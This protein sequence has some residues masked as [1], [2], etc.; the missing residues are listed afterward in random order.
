M[1]QG[2]RRIVGIRRDKV[3]E[4]RRRVEAGCKFQ[5]VAREVL[6]ANAQLLVLTN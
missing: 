3:A 6:A 5:E 4:A 1:A 2:R